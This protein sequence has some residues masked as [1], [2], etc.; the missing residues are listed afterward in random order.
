MR[1]VGYATVTEADIKPLEAVASSGA[2]LV[3]RVNTQVSMNNGK[4]IAYE[5]LCTFCYTRRKDNCIFFAYFQLELAK[6]KIRAARL[7]AFA[8]SFA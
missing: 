1:R 4:E 8:R 3:E 7:T 6:A 5:R 2:P